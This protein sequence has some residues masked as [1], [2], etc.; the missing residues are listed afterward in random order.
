MTTIK[1][2]SPVTFA[3][4]RF[5]AHTITNDKWH[6]PPTLDEIARACFVSNATVSNHLAFLNRMGKIERDSRRSRGI[7]LLEM[8]PEE[9]H[10][11]TESN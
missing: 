5:V 6:T 2:F 11:P 1:K 3:I 8:P 4:W 9:D 10:E 7:V